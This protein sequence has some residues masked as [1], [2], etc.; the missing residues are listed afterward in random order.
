MFNVLSYL[1]YFSKL[2]ASWRKLLFCFFF[3]LQN[4]PPHLSYVMSFLPLGRSSATLD[5][6]HTVQPKPIRD[7][8]TEIVAMDLG[9][10]KQHNLINV[11]FASNTETF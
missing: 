1:E 3:F 8:R 6:F 5:Y 11:Y 2:S 9:K 7:A 4:T 10:S